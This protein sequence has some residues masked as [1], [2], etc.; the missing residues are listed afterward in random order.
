MTT[1]VSLV[2]GERYGLGDLLGFPPAS[3]ERGTDGAYYLSRLASD[4]RGLDRTPITEEL[5]AA[6]IAQHVEARATN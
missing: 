3:V 1:T 4:L 2:P 6:L 5:A